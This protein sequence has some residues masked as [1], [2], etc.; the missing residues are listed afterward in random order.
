MV[1]I[2]ICQYHFLCRVQCTLPYRITL[3][4]HTE[5]LVLNALS[6]MTRQRDWAK[7]QQEQGNCILCG[8]KRTSYLHRCDKCQAK[9]TAK[10]RSG[11]I[12]EMVQAMK[13]EMDRA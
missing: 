9:V 4:N 6:T 5:F 2:E 13:K 11:R 8:L 12:A 10:A 7:R 3:D 1:G